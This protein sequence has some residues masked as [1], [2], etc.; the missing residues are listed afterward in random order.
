MSEVNQFG[1]D[2]YC[3]RVTKD[4]DLVKSLADAN[5]LVRRLWKLKRTFYIEGP[6]SYNQDE[7]HAQVWVDTTMTEEAL[8]NWL[9]KTKGIA[10]LGVFVRG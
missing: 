6:F 10:Y 1:I 3:G 7:Y 5:F 9:W 4:G 2:V 8:E